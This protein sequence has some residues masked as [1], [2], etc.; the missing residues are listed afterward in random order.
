MTGPAVPPAGGKDHLG[1][2]LV[3]AGV[4]T[5]TDLEVSLATA[6]NEGKRLGEVLVERKLATEEQIQNFLGIQLGF[7]SVKLAHTFIDPELARTVTEKYARRW[8]VLPLY[9][10]EAGDLPTAVVAMLDPTDI[11]V[12]DELRQALNGDIFPVLASPREMNLALDRTW[13]KAAGAPAPDSP[14]SMPITRPLAET[15]DAKP[16]VARLLQTLFNRALELNASSIQFEPKAR[17]VSVRFRIDGDYHAVT[18]LP[19][20]LYTAVL[21]RIKILAKI[22]LAESVAAV[23]EGRFHVHSGTPGPPIDLQVTVIPAVYG[24]KAVVKITH[25][26]QIIRPLE[27]LGFETEQLAAV[28]TLLRR[29]SGL[30]L[31]SGKH[32]SGMTT[33]AYSLLAALETPARLVVTIEERPAY[34]VASFNQVRKVDAAGKVRLDWEETLRA[35][36]RQEPHVVY[37]AG[38]QTL[39]EMRMILRLAASGRHVLSTLYADAAASTYWV[40][41]QLGADPHALAASL[42][43]VIHAR[44]LKRLCE[45]CRREAA[46]APETL[47]ALDLTVAAIGQKKYYEGAGCERCGGAGTSGRTGVFEILVMH[48]HL[49]EMIAAKTA[50]ALFRR[51]AC[52]AG[53]MTLREAALAKAERGEVSLREIAERLG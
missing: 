38:A 19:R 21:S 37:L 29:Q 25:R 27:A 52:E 12:Q 11:V 22:E 2:L 34:P 18:S 42:T 16:S 7:P 30:V 47:K 13:G 33:V 1:I 9:K 46:P 49:K 6:E 8:G 40:P 35:V 32:D 14:P 44:L 5:Q 31:V 51:A 41:F 39:E 23:V 50:S 4:I 15:G 26:R 48:E 36:E 53:M 45:F 24:E 20:D 43:C 3:R 28:Q 17:Y 10:S